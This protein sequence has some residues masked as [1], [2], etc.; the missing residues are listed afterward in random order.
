[1]SMAASK[2]NIVV[3]CVLESVGC[4]LASVNPPKSRSMTAAKTYHNL[5]F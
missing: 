1:M 2:H 4:V 3:G 5:E